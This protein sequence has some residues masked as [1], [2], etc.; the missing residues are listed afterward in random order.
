MI[1]SLAVLTLLIACSYAAHI[2][3]TPEFTTEQVTFDHFRHD[4]FGSKVYFSHA[5][6]KQRIDVDVIVVDNQPKKERVSLL[7]DFQNGKMYHIR[8]NL[9]SNVDTCV[10]SN[11][12][13][14]LEIPCLSKNARLRGRATLGATLHV[15]NWVEHVTDRN[16]TRAVVD[17]LLAAD[18]EVPVRVIDRHHEGREEVT[19]FWNFRERVQHDNFHPPTFCNGKEVQP[20]VI[21]NARQALKGISHKAKISP[22]F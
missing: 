22:I 2:C 11:L 17:I 15:D 9:T 19:E 21:K 18:I 8:Y 1:K 16:G 14:K 20:E 3:L 7:F 10:V 6:Q 12:T 13:G 4:I 5:L